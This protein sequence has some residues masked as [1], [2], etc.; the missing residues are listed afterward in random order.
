[1]LG[2]PELV[3]FKIL[4]FLDINDI[5]VVRLVAKRY[6]LLISKCIPFWKNFYVSPSIRRAFDVYGYKTYQ[7][8]VLTG[9]FPC[10]AKATEERDKLNKRHKKVR[11]QIH[12]RYDRIKDIKAEWIRLD[13]EWAEI[14]MNIDHSDEELK[15]EL[16]KELKSIS[17]KKRR[18]EEKEL[19]IMTEIDFIEGNISLTKYPLEKSRSKVRKLKTKKRKLEKILKRGDR[20]AKLNF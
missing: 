16:K 19:G 7:A 15:K 14:F 3:M 13:D 20:I 9:L 1:M 12:R 11:R 10:L 5:F 2:T 6:N 4:E 17:R 18:R 8:A